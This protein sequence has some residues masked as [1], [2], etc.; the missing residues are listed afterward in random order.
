MINQNNKSNTNSLNRIEPAQIVEMKS[1][2]VGSK[3]TFTC[4][5]G[6][7]LQGSNY[8]LECLITGSWSGSIPYCQGIF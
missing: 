8:E 2:S 1:R 5:R 4:P 3:V 6:Y 7:G